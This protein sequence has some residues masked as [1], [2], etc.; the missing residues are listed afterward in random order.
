MLVQDNKKNRN[1]DKLLDD[2]ACCAC[3]R[4][5]PLLIYIT[6][7]NCLHIHIYRPSYVLHKCWLQIDFAY[8]AP[9]LRTPT[10]PHQLS[11]HTIFFHWL[12]NACDTLRRRTQ[13]RKSLA[14]VL[15]MKINAGGKGE[16]VSGETNQFATLYTLRRHVSVYLSP[17]SKH[18]V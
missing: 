8:P 2:T 3:Y 5:W 1:N 18:V 10:P 4:I 7:K 15:H 12:A 13:F 9:F 16:N 14:N 6:K 17:E 11:I